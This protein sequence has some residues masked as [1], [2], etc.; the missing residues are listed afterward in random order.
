MIE[1][2][3]YLILSIMWSYRVGI[4]SSGVFGQGPPASPSLTAAAATQPA[5]SHGQHTC[6]TATPSDTAS[7]T[8]GAHYLQQARLPTKTT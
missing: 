5:K 3:F 6:V 7:T 1:V 4:V 2:Q 8:A